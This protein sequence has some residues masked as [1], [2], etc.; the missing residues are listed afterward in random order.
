ML[1]FKKEKNSTTEQDSGKKTEKQIINQL[2]EHL[3]YLRQSYFV[4]ENESSFVKVFVAERNIKGH[5]QNLGS[6]LIEASSI[7]Q[8]QEEIKER[9]G[10]G[11]YCVFLHKGSFRSKGVDILIGAGFRRRKQKQDFGKIAGMPASQIPTSALAR[12]KDIK[13]KESPTEKKKCAREVVYRYTGRKEER[14]AKWM[15]NLHTW[16]LTVKVKLHAEGLLVTYKDFLS[17]RQKLKMELLELPEEELKL[18]VDMH[19]LE[20]FKDHLRQIFLSRYE[21]Y[22]IEDDIWDEGDEE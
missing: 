9:Y 16:W 12:E 14:I 6:F 20:A 11:R 19:V 18:V 13:K 2:K 10:Q 4:T 17:A 21:I 3:E 8:L 15:T 1:F 7:E 5:L 22:D